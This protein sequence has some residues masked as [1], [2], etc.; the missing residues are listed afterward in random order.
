MAASIADK[1]YNE[2]LRDSIV[3]K[4]EAADLQ[5]TRDY[6]IDLY[7]QSRYDSMMG[8][9]KITY[10]KDILDYLPQEIVDY[11]EEHRND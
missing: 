4:N 10:H 1:N 7:Q 8:L 3:F 5:G 11:Y 2:E 6:I 9:L